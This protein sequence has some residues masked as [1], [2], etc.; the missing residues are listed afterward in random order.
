MG[1][2]AIY[3]WGFILR[4]VFKLLMQVPCISTSRVGVSVIGSRNTVPTRSYILGPSPHQKLE[5]AAGPLGT[6]PKGERRGKRK[7]KKEKKNLTIHTGSQRQVF[8][9]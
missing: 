6:P 5:V 2:F 9:K 8:T 3:I 7:S 4:N 1:I